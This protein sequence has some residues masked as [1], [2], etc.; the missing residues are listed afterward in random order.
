MAI[1]I[2]EIKGTPTVA[3]GKIKMDSMAI[4]ELCEEKKK[5]QLLWL[6]KGK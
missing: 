4:E 5:K 6:K 2:V 1:A 3:K